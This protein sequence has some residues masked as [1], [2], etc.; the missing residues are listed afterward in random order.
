MSGQCNKTTRIAPISDVHSEFLRSPGEDHIGWFTNQIVDEDSKHTILVV[1]GD[2]DT[3]CRN[4]A[5]WIESFCSKFKHVIAVAGNHEHY[6]SCI[7]IGAMEVYESTKHIKNFSF[8][9]NDSVIVDGVQFIGCTLWS[10]CENILHMGHAL[11]DYSVI[12]G[13]DGKPI[14]PQDTLSLHRESVG[15]LYHE[16]NKSP[17]HKR[18]VVTHH[19]PSYAAVTPQFRGS[20]LN[21]FFTSDLNALIEMGRPDLW[22]FGHTHSSVDMTLYDTRLVCNPYGYNGE[23][24]EFNPK[25]TIEI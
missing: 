10:N 3:P 22:L 23:N 13:G 7:H 4:V 2:L 24:T 15:Y 6:N 5:P 20:R 11:G 9:E 25:L 12:S 21:P 16:L 18:V 14:K 17:G 1:A 19:M 8:L